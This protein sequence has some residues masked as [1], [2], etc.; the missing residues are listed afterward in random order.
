VKVAYYLVTLACLGVSALAL[1]KAYLNL[2]YRLIYWAGLGVAILFYIGVVL[3]IARKMR[4]TAKILV[5]SIALQL[6]PLC[7]TVAVF[8]FLSVISSRPAVGAMNKYERRFNDLQSVQKVAAENNGL[9]PFDSRAELNECYEALC[10]EGKLVK[11]SSNS[12]YV[13]RE[14]TYSAP[15]VV[16]KVECLLNDIA[17]SFQE[18]AGSKVRFEVTSVLRTKEDVKRLQKVNANATTTSCHCYA[19][20]IDISYVRFSKGCMNTQ[21]GADLRLALAQAVDELRKAKR[22][23]VKIEQK[24]CCYH[25]TVR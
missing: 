21:K 22:C 17:K 5:H 12:G 23:Y 3:L 11:I 16:P 18:K 7:A 4:G 25:I 20:T 10:K 8:C 9:P 2:H 1:Y 24:Q 19:T 6:I 13:V 14:L 15:Y